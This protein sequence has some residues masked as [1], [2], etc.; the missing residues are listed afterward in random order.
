MPR[1]G[2]KFV[3][4]TSRQQLNPDAPRSG[5]RYWLDVATAAY[6]LVLVPVALIVL[7]VVL[8]VPGL[9]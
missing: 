9:A 1:T 6:P 5:W 3:V 7:G 8:L 2:Y 4:D